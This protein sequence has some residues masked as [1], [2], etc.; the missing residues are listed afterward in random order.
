MGWAVLEQVLASHWGCITRIAIRLAHLELTVHMSIHP[1][2]SCSM[3]NQDDLVCSVQVVVALCGVEVRVVLLSFSFCGEPYWH[4]QK[5]HDTFSYEAVMRDTGC[6]L[7]MFVECHGNWVTDKTWLWKLDNRQN[8]AD[9]ITCYR[10]SNVME[11]EQLTRHSWSNN[12]LQG[13]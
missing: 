1:V 7:L 11:T 3:S 6:L 8:M 10:D 5:T 2:V 13:Q 9:Q 4:T 12:M